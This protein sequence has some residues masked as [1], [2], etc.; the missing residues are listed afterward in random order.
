MNKKRTSSVFAAL[1]AMLLLCPWLSVAREK[2]DTQ[3][4]VRENLMLR[5]SAEWYKLGVLTRELE[6]AN[7]VTDGIKDIEMFPAEV[8]RLSENDVLALDR[9]LETI[10]KQNGILNEKITA[11]RMPLADA[12]AILREMIIGQPVEDMFTILENGDM[13]RI[14]TMLD[15]KHQVDRLWSE[16]DSTL[17]S[18]AIGMNITGVQEDTETAFNTEF[19]KILQANLGHQSEIYQNKIAV[20][21]D[22]LV[23]RGT[24]DQA[25]VMFNIEKYRIKKNLAANANSGILKHIENLQKRY[26]SWPWVA[27]LKP[28]LIKNCFIVGD[29]QRV[30]DETDTI[31]DND[32]M[33]VSYRMQSLYG[34]QRFSDV[35]A[36][37]QN[38][39]WEMLPA[40]FKNLSIWMVLESGL[41]IGVED[42]LSRFASYVDKQQPWLLHC[43]HTLAR[44]SLKKGDQSTALSILDN[45]LKYKAQNSADEVA[46]QRILLMRGQMLYESGD[47]KKAVSDFFE[48]LNSGRDF[49]EALFGIIWCYI[50]TGQYDNADITL[51]KLI[52]QS[53][54]SP[55][56]AEATALLARRYTAKAQYEWKKTSYLTREQQRIELMLDKMKDIKA[57]TS[58]AKAKRILAAK[59]E[60]DDLF[61][62]LKA[63]PRSN[64]DTISRLYQRAQRVCDLVEQFY[65]T[66]SF[67]E[68]VFSE[69]REK[70]L[71]HVDSIMA[72]IKGQ[73]TTSKN[74]TSGAGEVSAGNIARIKKIV[75]DQRVEKTGF[76][77]DRYR[78]EREYLDWQKVALTHSREMLAAREARTKDSAAR[79]LIRL[80]IDSLT[81]QT[82][83]L[84][85][86]EDSLRLQ[87][88]ETILAACSTSISQG[89]AIPD[90]I[91]LRYH[92]GEIRYAQENDAYGRA[93]DEFENS[94]H[95]YDSLLALYR[96]GTL[97]DI[98]EKPTEPLLDHSR[99][100][101]QYLSVLQRFPDVGV[102]FAVRYSLAWC[103]NDL[104]KFD[105]AVAQM[106]TISSRYPQCAYAPQANMFIG[107]F[108]FDRGN[109]E[110]AVQRY[111][112][113]MKYPE[114]DWFEDALYKLAWS[115]YRLSNPDKAISSFLALVDLGGKLISGKGILEK[116]SMDYIAISFSEADATGTKGLERAVKFVKRLG[117]EEKGTRILQRMAEVY[118]DQGRYEVS[119]E[120]YQTIL[121][122]YPGYAASPMIEKDLMN[123]ASRAISVAQSNEMKLS[124]FN[125]YNKR[126]PWARSQKNT[127]TIAAADSMAERALYD[128]AIGNHQLAQQKND[129]DAYMNAAGTYEL[130]LKNYPGTPVANE[131]HYFLADIVFT[132]GDYQRAAEEYIAVSKRYP[133]S[134]YRES[135]AWNA[136]VA[137]QQ[138]LKQEAKNQ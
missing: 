4:Q 134:K 9:R 12:I 44:L 66:G 115:Q 93:Y 30:I 129:H 51:Q 74:G 35:Y 91:Y 121:D 103:Y 61:A 11:M 75:S 114:S 137:S 126:G 7:N 111:Q 105:S 84:L 127:A 1:C 112:L 110:A 64:Y 102:M 78:W 67:Q 130:Y 131:C 120:A 73:N 106:D 80:A 24:L 15:I 20:I 17:N 87:W 56:A 43:M 47:Y 33:A 94:F 37:G 107:E 2:Q 86:S 60:M 85:S 8:T 96:K 38:I 108:N 138:L 52:N 70:L 89:V 133:D 5:L 81:R 99:S 39:A 82:D 125:K 135:A 132:L 100:M 21:K 3:W 54:E 104:G 10:V 31:R 46:H 118:R 6:N 68:A 101:D 71:H 36:M 28:L 62:R 48:V 57:D 49:E 26:Q 25:H 45:S 53:P 113:V 98:P 29:Y 14:N 40:K 88:S 63:E 72:A 16:I 79:F 41:K 65:K 18:L 32:T 69:K 27:D 59:K 13:M 23:N 50:K 128:V 123:V 122:M 116:E 22:S 42:S 92:I 34:L 76:L 136:I 97:T 19:L 119:R 77:I 109:L 117:D 90:E 55:R 83:R 95:I 58:A 124:Y